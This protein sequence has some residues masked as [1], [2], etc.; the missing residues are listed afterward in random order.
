MY[1]GRC[2]NRVDEN[3][4]CAVCAGKASAPQ[5]TEEP[6]V[7][8]QIPKQKK[9]KTLASCAWFAPVAIV[10]AFV[11]SGLLNSIPDLIPDL[12]YSFQGTRSNLIR[13]LL[14]VPF[15]LIHSFLIYYVFYRIALA[16]QPKRIR[17]LTCASF[18]IPMAT[19]NVISVFI[20]TVP[21]IVAYINAV[22]NN[23]DV[24][25]FNDVLFHSDII[26]N[27]IGTAYGIAN[28]LAYV[29]SAVLSYILLRLYF[30]VIEKNIVN[31]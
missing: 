10:S 6:F 8:K 12:S 7:Q 16:K 21:G 17:R 22:N 30:R 25:D 18:L 4:F 29:I 11:L 14:Y 31:V 13:T 19:E 26:N 27:G 5:K 3:G 9:P 1:C 15:W 20:G 28:I 23:V 24:Y 2:G